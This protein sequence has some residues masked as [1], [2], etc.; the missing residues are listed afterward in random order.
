M[1]LAFRDI[2]QYESIRTKIKNQ[3]YGRYGMSH[4]DIA[5]LKVQLFT[6][7]KTAA[8]QSKI[9]LEQILETARK[10]NIPTVVVKPQLI[11]FIGHDFFVD[12]DGILGEPDLAQFKDDDALRWANSPRWRE[13]T[14]SRGHYML[15]LGG[16]F[17][18]YW[19][20]SPH[21]GYY[22][23][24]HLGTDYNKITHRK[25]QIQ[26]LWDWGWPARRGRPVHVGFECYSGSTHEIE[27]LTDMAAQ[28]WTRQRSSEVAKRACANYRSINKEYALP[29]NW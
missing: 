4:E 28:M 29:G 25:T 12:P 10:R 8:E 5:G 20:Q 15:E 19:A 9:N 23:R 26:E 21:C 22:Q 3:G 6:L 11:Q 14:S 2:T 17:S 7:T 16:Y 27:C 13:E 24:N 18:H 1:D